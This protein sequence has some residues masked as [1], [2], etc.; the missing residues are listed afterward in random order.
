M[1]WQGMTGLG[2]AVKARPGMTGLGKAVKAR[3]DW[4]RQGSAWPGRASQRTAHNRR[5]GAIPRPS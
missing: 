4:D 3:P 5:G 2:K 1:A